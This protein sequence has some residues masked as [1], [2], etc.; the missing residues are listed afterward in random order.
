M[1]G[2]RSSLLVLMNQTPFGRHIYAV[3]GNEAA[4]RL[5]GLKV[6]RI[7]IIMYVLSGVLAAL[8][9]MLLTAKAGTALPDAAP[10][11]ELDV[12]AAVIIGGT[13]L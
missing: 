2:R 1:L 7:K 12:I 6:E 9:G 11:Y 8:G 5:L 3:G 10:G 4:A 13:S